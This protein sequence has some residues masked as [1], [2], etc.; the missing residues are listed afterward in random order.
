[1][2]FVNYHVRKKGTLLS[3]YYFLRELVLLTETWLDTYVQ[4]EREVR[5]GGSVYPCIPTRT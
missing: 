4:Q 2:T 5:W 1:M 3:F